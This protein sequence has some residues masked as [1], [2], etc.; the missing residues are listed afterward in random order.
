[1]P[2]FPGLLIDAPSILI[3]YEFFGSGYHFYGN[4]WFFDSLLMGSSSL[5]NWGVGVTIIFFYNKLWAKL[6]DT[7][8]IPSSGIPIY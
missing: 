7:I 1:M 5:L 6:F 3:L 4:F 8:Q 2:T